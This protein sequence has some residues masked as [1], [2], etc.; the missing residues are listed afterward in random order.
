MPPTPRGKGGRLRALGA[1]GGAA[2]TA[3]PPARRVAQVSGFR[4]SVWA[5]HLG[6]YDPLFLRPHDPECAAKVRAMAQA[7]WDAYVSP[8][9]QPLPHGHL[10]TYPYNIQSDGG[11]CPLPEGRGAAPEDAAPS[12]ESPVGGGGGGMTVIVVL[13]VFFQETPMFD[14]LCQCVAVFCVHGMAG[15]V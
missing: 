6:C 4:L 9:L 2:R 15:P 1:L 14:M 13:V 8:E 11:V 5:E 7:N 3:P 10:M 12:P